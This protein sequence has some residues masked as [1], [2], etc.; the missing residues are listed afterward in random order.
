MLRRITT[1]VLIKLHLKKRFPSKPAIETLLDLLPLIYV[2][3]LIVGA[4][5]WLC[6]EGIHIPWY[7]QWWYILRFRLRR[8]RAVLIGY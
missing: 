8:L 4:V 1:W 7:R 3:S 2:A 6:P 5:K